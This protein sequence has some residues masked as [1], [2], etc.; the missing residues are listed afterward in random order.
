MA[1]LTVVIP[2]VS[3]INSTSQ[4][5]AFITKNFLT[6]VVIPFVSGINS[7]GNL[8]DDNSKYERSSRNSLR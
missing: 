5:G 2:F 4:N 3:G 1:K 7:T 8:V 6:Q